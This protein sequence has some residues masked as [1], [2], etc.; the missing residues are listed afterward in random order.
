MGR[1]DGRGAVVAG[2]GQGIG[3]AIATVFAREGAKVCVAEVKAHRGD[4]TV[5]AIRDA[6]GDAFA[7]ACDVGVKADVQAM[8]DA[9]VR[10][11]GTVDVLVNNA[12]GF[13]P[14]ARLEEIPDEQ[15]DMS[16]RT[17]TKGTWWGMCAVRPIMAAKG[18]GRIVNFGSL[19]AE[20]GHAGL[21]ESGAAKAG[22]TSLTC[23]AAREWGHSGIT[24]NVIY[25][26]AYTKRGM[27]FR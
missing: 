27:D 2:A 5:A 24:V 12:H 9:T 17:G 20:Q 7:L 11:W 22:I 13:G 23:T 14:R 16:W 4:R 19:A 25:P 15:F 8:V 26:A 21:G 3:A 10:R 1:H 18:R 6:G